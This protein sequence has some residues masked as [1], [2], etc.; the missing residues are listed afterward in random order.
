MNIWVN[1]PKT[2]RPSVSLTFFAYGFLVCL[3]KLIFS[4][5]EFGNFTLKEFGGVDFGAAVGALGAVYTM[6]KNRSIK[7]S[8]KSE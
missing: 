1:D 6:R 4:G 5:V 8:E 7:E 2:G 3:L